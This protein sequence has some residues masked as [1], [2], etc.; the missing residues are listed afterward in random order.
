M[1]LRLSDEQAEALRRRAA[2]EGRSVQQV[3]QAA[4]DAYLQQ[5]AH[6][7]RQ[8][9]PVAELL[10]NFGGLAP[11]DAAAFRADADAAL[12]PTAYFDAY[13]RAT[14]PLATRTADQIDAAVSD[15]TGSADKRS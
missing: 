8:A 9:V 13:E 7:Q 2:A 3:A 6:R 15:A 11:A 4:I 1:N 14:E 5:P 12:D 10:E